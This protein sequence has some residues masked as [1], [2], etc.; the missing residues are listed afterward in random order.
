MRTGRLEGKVALV[1]GAGSGIG[2]AAAM[3]FA[4]EG[5]QVAVLDIRP[6]LAALT[7]MMI[8]KEHE[9]QALA[10]SADVGNAVEIDT[11]VDLAAAEF[12]RLDVVYNN[13]GVDS[14][15]SV[16]DAA[17]DDWDRA[18]GVNAKGTF[19]T[20]RAAL[21]HMGG[22]ARSSTRVPWPVS[23]ACRASPRT[24]PRRAR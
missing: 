17:E 15:G 11:A 19:L 13:A 7:T 16:A 2:Q 5:A 22:A 21:T 1:T 6:E 18:F 23:S 24:A 20:S 12:G 9:D 8:E 3:L 4:A 14:T 10:L